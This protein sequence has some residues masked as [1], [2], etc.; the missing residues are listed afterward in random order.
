MSDTASPETHSPNTSANTGFFGV[1][2]G[3]FHF[4]AIGVAVLVAAI[5]QFGYP[6]V[7]SLALLA[8]FVAIAM[9]VGLTAIDLVHQP[10]PA[11]AVRERAIP[12]AAT[13][14]A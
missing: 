7:I 8:A 13:Q 6:L 3:R 9:L 5:Y 14:A 10:K 4:A 11:R 1:A 2:D 12:S